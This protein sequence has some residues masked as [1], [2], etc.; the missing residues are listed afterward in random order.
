[1]GQAKTDLG[2]SFLCYTGS[3]EG[4]K[5]SEKKAN[6]F[7]K[8]FWKSQ[9]LEV[10]GHLWRQGYRINENRIGCMSVLAI[11]RLLTTS[12]A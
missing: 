12:L 9:E 3:R 5:S 1:M 10:S 7:I 8:S 2:F 6:S 4:K 11:I